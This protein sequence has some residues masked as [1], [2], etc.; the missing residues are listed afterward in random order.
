MRAT[1]SS[2]PVSS[3]GN[4]IVNGDFFN[5]GSQNVMKKTGGILNQHLALVY[6]SA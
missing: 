1:G 6:V 2:S 3:P 5:S 4:S